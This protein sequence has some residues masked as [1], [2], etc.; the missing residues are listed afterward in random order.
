MSINKGERDM[1]LKFPFKFKCKGDSTV[2]SAEEHKNSNKI[3]VSWYEYDED[4]LH[5]LKYSV[6]EVLKYIIAGNWTITD[7]LFQTSPTVEITQEEYDSMVEEIN[8]LQELLAEQLTKP[9]YLLIGSDI[10]FIK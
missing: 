3:M 1:S 9:K 5:Q 2:F 8:L 7:E 10:N 6:E 4:E